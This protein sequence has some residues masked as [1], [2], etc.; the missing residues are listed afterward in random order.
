MTLLASTL[1]ITTLLGQSPTPTPRAAPAPSRVKRPATTFQPSKDRARKLFASGQALYAKRRYRQ[2]IE[3][4]TE[5]LRHWNRR[6][7]HF[8]IALCFYELNNAVGAIRHLRTY[9]KGA[10]RREKRAVPRPLRRLRRKVGLVVIS[11]SD[12]NAEIWID[13]IP[14]G[15]GKAEWV[16]RPGAVQVAIHR[17]GATNVKRTLKARAGGT[18]Y[19]DVTVNRIRVEGP[20]NGGSRT[21]LHWQW[22]TA[23]AGVAVVAAGLAVGFGIKAG[24]IHD[25][26]D[27]NPT[28]DLRDRGIR[29]QTLTNVMWG[30]AGVAAVTAA[31]LVYFTRWKRRERSSVKRFV[32]VITPTGV[33]LTGRF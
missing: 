32:P 27:A 17:S 11:S 13:G 24:K 21:R 5:A 26:F 3:A 29:F 19:W 2:A 23:A 33:A 8:N 22:F 9:L 7:I 6:E 1:L 20:A 15:K 14:R 25:E 4:L 10:S 30:V 12:T 28:W 18:T 16:V 31:V